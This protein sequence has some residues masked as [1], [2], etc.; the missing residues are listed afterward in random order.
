MCH[1]PSTRVKRFCVRLVA[2][3]R[4]DSG[5]ELFEAALVLPVLLVLLLGI[6]T[7]GRAY[8]TYQTIT[9][10][11]REGAKAAVLTPC[12]DSTYCS[13]A[14]NYTARDIWINFVDP[15]LQSDNLDTTQVTNNTITYVQLDPNG[16]PA[17]VCGVQLQFS[18]PYTF[19]LPFT[20]LNLSTIT[21]KTTVQMRLENQ[22]ATCPV[23]SNY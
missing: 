5:A 16:S 11:A 6:V 10:A 2:K 15:V 7:F 19:S 13:G 17:H 18:Y 20:T 9:R 1:R 8:N 4:E 21:L 12:A 3:A 14:T 22:P 23:G